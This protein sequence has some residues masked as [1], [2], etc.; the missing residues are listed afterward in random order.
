MQEIPGAT[1]GQATMNTANLLS[2]GTKDFA[3]EEGKTI[4][5]LTGTGNCT[6]VPAAGSADGDAW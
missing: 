4:A 6:M 2:G 1:L 3:T 5:G